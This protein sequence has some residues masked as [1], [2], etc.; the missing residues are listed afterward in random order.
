MSKIAIQNRWQREL[1]GLKIDKDGEKVR[2]GDN[3]WIGRDAIILPG[4]TISNH[5][6]IGAGAVVTKDVEKFEVVGGNPA[7]N[8]RYRFNKEI[9]DKIEEMKFT[10]MTNTELKENIDFFEKSFKRK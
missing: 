6:I 3:V 2:I 5:A 9:R 10:N 8:I 4:V 7:R 1:L